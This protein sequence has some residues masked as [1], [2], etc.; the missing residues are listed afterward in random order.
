MHISLIMRREVCC[1][2]CDPEKMKLRSCAIMTLIEKGKLA[3][4][5]ELTGSSH[6]G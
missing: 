1:C 4:K 5:D 3:G 2:G 6:D